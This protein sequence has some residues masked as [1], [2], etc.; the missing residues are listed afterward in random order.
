V[1]SPADAPFAC[2]ESMTAPTNA[3]VTGS[4]RLVEPGDDFT[5]RFSITPGEL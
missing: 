5:A 2:L 4:C 1:Y 3:L